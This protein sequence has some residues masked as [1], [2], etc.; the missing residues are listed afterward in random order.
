M[1][2]EGR[3]EKKIEK[4]YTEEDINKRLDQLAA[5]IDGDY[6]GEEI[7]VVGVLK[8]SFIFMAD[9]VRRIKC[10]TRCDFMRVASYENDES[11]GYVRMEFDLTQPIHDQHV[12]LV[13]DIVDSGRT[14]TYLLKHLKQ[15]SPKSLKV[16]TLLH[17]EDMGA[18]PGMIDY[19]GFTVPNKYVIG[20]GL[21][22]MGLYRS[23]PYIGYFP[24]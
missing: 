17:K 23:L 10:P 7:T 14:L 24:K 1:E 20:Y 9:L 12:L 5:K 2:G 11:T 19:K 22:S 6:K 15:Q 3:M 18:D 13:E 8:G 16:C 21:D 4:L